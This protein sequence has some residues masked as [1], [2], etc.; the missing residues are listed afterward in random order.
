MNT[1]TLDELNRHIHEGH[2]L[3]DGTSPVIIRCEHGDHAVAAAHWDGGLLVIDL[4]VK[5]SLT[6]FKAAEKVW[7]KEQ[8]KTAHDAM[9]QSHMVPYRDKAVCWLIAKG[10]SYRVD[11]TADNA[12]DVAEQ[13]AYHEEVARR[14]DLTNG[15]TWHDFELQNCDGSCLGWNGIDHRCQCGNR[16][17]SWRQS[18]AHTFENPLIFAEAY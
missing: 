7:L 18:R 13:I 9:A 12:V 16:R 8:E 6:A 2:G 14:Q 4:G 3:V 17:V 10:K 11:F 5:L 1:L 15:P